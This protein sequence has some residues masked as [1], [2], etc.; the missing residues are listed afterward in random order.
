M[1]KWK[2]VN[3]FHWNTHHLF[4]SGDFLNLWHFLSIEIPPKKIIPT[5]PRYF[6]RNINF[7]LVNL[8][9]ASFVLYNQAGY[10][11]FDSVFCFF[12]TSK[13]CP[14][15]FCLSWPIC[16]FACHLRY[17]CRT[18]TEELRLRIMRVVR[19]APAVTDWKGWPITH[20]TP[21]SSHQVCTTSQCLS[22]DPTASS[23]WGSKFLVTRNS[24]KL[25][26]WG[27]LCNEMNI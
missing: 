5:K 21:L 15:T 22:W 17:S 1:F 14:L 12:V 19:K 23:P 10:V 11:S 9:I 20:K 25:R 4:W 7:I 24:L 18:R 2:N 26:L 13:I 27:Y 6:L 8:H 16:K 3:I